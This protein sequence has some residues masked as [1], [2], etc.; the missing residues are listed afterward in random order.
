MKRA[1]FLDRDGTLIQ[2]RGYICDFSRSR[3]FPLRRGRRAHPEPGRVPG[4]R[5]QQPVGRGP[6]HLQR[7]AGRAS[8]TGGCRAISKSAGPRSPPS[9]TA[10][11]S[12]TPRCPPTAATAPCASPPR[13]CCCRQRRFRP[14]APPLFHGRR[15]GRRHRSRQKGGL[16]D[17]A[18]AHRPG[19]SDAATLAARGS[20]PD[21]MADDLGAAARAI[22]ALGRR[23]RGSA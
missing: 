5:G 22:A 9:T 11:S 14:G 7:S 23:G 4:H 10:R 12:A 15:Q 19:E 18:G 20:G 16:P 8:C 2:D 3:L 13:A 21:H 1:V 6:R 17:R